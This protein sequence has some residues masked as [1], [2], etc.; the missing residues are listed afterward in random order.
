MTKKEMPSMKR[1]DR[2][3]PIVE[4]VKAL[5]K[6]WV[7]TSDNILTVV[8]KWFDRKLKEGILCV[9]GGARFL[10]KFF[11]KLESQ[12]RRQMQN[13]SFRVAHAT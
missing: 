6:S 8:S 12:P 13:A 7:V 10:A 3:V 1:R 5:N 4:Q 9:T 2:V 11:R